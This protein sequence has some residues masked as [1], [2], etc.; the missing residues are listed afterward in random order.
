MFTGEHEGAQG[1]NTSSPPGPHKEIL[2]GNFEDLS[3]E[4]PPPP[5]NFG[6]IL[7]FHTKFFGKPET[8]T[9]CDSLRIQVFN[10][11]KYEKS[12]RIQY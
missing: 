1:V 4:L 11:K 12:M 6:S 2:L 8:I 7:N 5:P 9:W 10:A 3:K